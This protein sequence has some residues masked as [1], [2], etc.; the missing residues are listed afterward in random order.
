[1]RD[2]VIQKHSHVISLMCTPRL[3]LRS[4]GYFDKEKTKHY[5]EIRKLLSTVLIAVKKPLFSKRHKKEVI[6]STK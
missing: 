5:Q 3:G 6:T 1:M 4:G 2:D